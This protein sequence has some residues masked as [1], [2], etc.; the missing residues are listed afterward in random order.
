MNEQGT[1]YELPVAVCIC[2]RKRQ[3]GLLKLLQSLNEMEAPEE[4]YISIIIVENDTEPFSEKLVRDYS[5]TSRYKTHYFLEP[6]LGIVN[7]RNRSVANE[8]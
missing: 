3:D 5:L 1:K 7:A 2:T 6:K 4:T 8:S